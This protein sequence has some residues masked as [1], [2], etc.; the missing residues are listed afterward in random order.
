MIL[1]T[2]I[3]SLG[4]GCQHARP[5]PA[6]LPSTEEPANFGYGVRGS[7]SP[8]ASISSQDA[9]DLE[10]RKATHVAELLEGR[11]PGVD[12][13]RTSDGGFSVRI[14]GRGSFLGDGEPLYVIDGLA[15]EVPAGYGM[16][17]L[18]PADISRIDVLKDGASTALY[19][20]RGGNGVIVITTKRGR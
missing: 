18:N 8:T 13:I 2:V 9:R 15:V 3:V 4:A 11:F 1:L 7:I 10:N 16:T 14:R 12:V 20:S 6:T 17:W 5:Q 19:G